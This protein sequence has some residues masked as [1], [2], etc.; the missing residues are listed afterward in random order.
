MKKIHDEL[1]TERFLKLKFGHYSHM[2]SPLSLAC[3]YGHYDMV[4][5][6][7]SIGADVNVVEQGSK[8]NTPLIFACMSR[9]P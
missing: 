7:V 3:C 9:K 2:D 5:F 8:N 1:G 4:E 6:L